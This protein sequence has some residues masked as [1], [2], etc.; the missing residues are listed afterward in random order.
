MVV[1]LSAGNV[2]SESVHIPPSIG[3]EMK[4][5][6]SVAVAS[7]LVQTVS[8]GTVSSSESPKN[9]KTLPHIVFVLTDDNGWAGVGYNNPNLNTPTLD[10]L[11]ETGLKLTSHYTYKYCAP[12]RGVSAN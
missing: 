4:L 6:A 1:N 8:A 3:I 2:A 9:S 10:H 11:A 7:A 5:F 12:T